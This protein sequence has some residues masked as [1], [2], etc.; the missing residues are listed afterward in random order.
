MRKL[1][2]NLDSLAVQS[3]DTTPAGEGARGTVQGR[4]MGVHEPASHPDCP[5]PLCVDTPLASCDGSCGRQTYCYESCNGT[6]ESCG[7]TCA[8]SCGTCGDTCPES[9]NPSCGPLCVPP[10]PVYP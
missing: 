6:C 4:G 9:C 8:A 2:L 1:V 10:D 3:F 5:S 7:Y